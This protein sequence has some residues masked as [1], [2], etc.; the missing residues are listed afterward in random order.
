[1][2]DHVY[3]DSSGLAKLILTKEQ[4]AAAQRT[5]DLYELALLSGSSLSDCARAPQ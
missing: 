3:F 5:R 4:G 1:M 2:L